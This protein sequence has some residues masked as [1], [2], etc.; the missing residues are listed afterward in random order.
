MSSA[1]RDLA[2]SAVALVFF[3][4]EEAGLDVELA[5]PDAVNH[6]GRS[7]VHLLD[8]QSCCKLDRACMAEE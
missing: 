5:S 6:A 8:N 2:V 7:E 3:A 1:Y 4:P